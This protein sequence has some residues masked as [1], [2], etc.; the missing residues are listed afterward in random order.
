MNRPTI[1]SFVGFL[2]A[3]SA[4]TPETRA[5]GVIE[6]FVSVGPVKELV[7]V[8]AAADT[9][10]PLAEPLLWIESLG[11]STGEVMKVHL[12][13]PTPDPIE[14]DGYVA[15]EPVDLSPEERDRLRE[16]IQQAFGTH[17]EALI[18]FYCLQFGAAAP[19][20]GI[21]FRIAG[22]E[23]QARFRR[24]AHALEAARQLNEAGRLSPDTN[25]ESYYHSIR[26][27][28]VWTLERG[29]DRDGFLEAFLEHTKKNVEARGQ[30][31]TD[32]FADVARRSA[33]GR[34]QDIT[35]VLEAAAQI[36]ERAE[37]Q[38]Q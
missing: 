32:E 29:F 36:D 28:A 9:D 35:Q 15:L 11:G 26:Q 34:W 5:Q 2:A 33:E 37:S 21:V 23:K 14:I 1:L 10:I 4:A 16:S 38:E 31:W 20:E 27:W 25:P 18:S 12:V 13:N 7:N 24:Q 8:G 3:T 22:P 30:G 17:V 6:G 19:A